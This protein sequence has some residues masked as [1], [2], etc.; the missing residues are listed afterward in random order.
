LLYATLVGFGSAFSKVIASWLD[1]GE[2]L[3]PSGA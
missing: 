2:P 3:T 1:R